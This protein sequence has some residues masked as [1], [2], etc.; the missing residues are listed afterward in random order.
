MHSVSPFLAVKGGGP[1]SLADDFSY[2]LDQLV[3]AERLEEECVG[4]G[5][6]AFDRTI[7]TRGH[8]DGYGLEYLVP[9]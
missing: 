5:V 3:R 2:Q 6:D 7:H 8:D 4:A 1:A 9:L